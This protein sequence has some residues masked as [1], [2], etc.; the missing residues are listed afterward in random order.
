MCLCVH[1]CMCFN[2][3]EQLRF[4]WGFFCTGGNEDMWQELP[5][6][7]LHD[8]RFT[9]VSA[10]NSMIYVNNAF[11]LSWNITQSKHDR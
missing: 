7:D 9:A 4:V 10:R 5:K 1:V 8:V 2:Y 11:K 3:L 6:P